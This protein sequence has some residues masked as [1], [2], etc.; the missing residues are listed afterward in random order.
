MRD[1]IVHEST[2]GIE[3]NIDEESNIYHN[4]R[5]EIEKSI[6]TILE[7]EYIVIRII[8]DFTYKNSSPRNH[9]G[10]KI[11]WIFDTRNK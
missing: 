4:L 8:A 6:K 9:I 2:L 10:N 3:K 11:K 7:A 1:Y 5:D